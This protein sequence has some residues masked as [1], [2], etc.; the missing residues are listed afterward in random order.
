MGPKKWNFVRTIATDT[1]GKWSRRLLSWLP[2]FRTLPACNVGRPRIR[3]AQDP[4]HYCGGDWQQTASDEAL[5]AILRDG[6]VLAMSGMVQWEMLRHD[7]LIF[8]ISKQTCLC[9][10]AHA[11]VSPVLET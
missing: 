6:F 1:L 3:W 4:E 5:W 7:W 2:W 10:E 9:G 8:A 11:G